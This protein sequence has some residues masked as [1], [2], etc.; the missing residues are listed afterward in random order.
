[1]GEADLATPDEYLNYRPWI[2]HVDGLSTSEASGAGLILIGLEGVVTEYAL[3]FAFLVSNNE[4]EYEVLIIGLKL[5]LELRT[6]QLKVC[7]SQLIVNQIRG[8]F[9][10]RSPTMAT[11]K[12]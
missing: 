6:H 7:D 9:E 11:Y 8:N 1:M 10:A 2:L 12:R 5:A 3:Y 4:A